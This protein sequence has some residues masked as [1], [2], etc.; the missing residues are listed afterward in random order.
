MNLFNR[1]Y[2]EASYARPT[3]SFRRTT[4]QFHFDRYASDMQIRTASEKF[5]VKK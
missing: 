5:A 1:K 4:G 3:F 2:S